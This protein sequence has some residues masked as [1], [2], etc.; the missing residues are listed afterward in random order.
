MIDKH[1]GE[2][3]WGIL[4]AKEGD[5]VFSKLPIANIIKKHL[6]KKVKKKYNLKKKLYKVKHINK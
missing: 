4:F 6:N 2:A 5:K 3:Y 1:R